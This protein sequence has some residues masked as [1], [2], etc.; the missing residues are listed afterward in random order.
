MWTR[1]LPACSPRAS[2]G[3]G[4]EAQLGA[5]RA[6][7]RQ[8]FAPELFVALGSPVLWA[9]ASPDMLGPL[10]RRGRRRWDGRTAAV[11]LWAL[12][13]GIAPRSLR[14]VLDL[15]LRLGDAR[16]GRRLGGRPYVE[17]RPQGPARAPRET[18]LP[19]E[20]MAVGERSVSAASTLPSRPYMSL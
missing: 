8:E 16:A 9:G 3:H 7:A 4:Y 15:R 2:A 17:W 11:W 10:R 14:A 13:G 6:S 19:A 18:Q 20:A 5:E 1:A 12:W